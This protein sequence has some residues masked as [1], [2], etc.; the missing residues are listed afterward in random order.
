MPPPLAH[1]AFKPAEPPAPADDVISSQWD[2]ALTRS[3][4]WGRLITG[5][6]SLEAAGSQFC[7]WGGGL[8]TSSRPTWVLSHPNC[9]RGRAC[10]Q[11]PLTALGLPLMSPHTPHWRCHRLPRSLA[12]R[13]LPS[14][15]LDAPGNRDRIVHCGD[16]RRSWGATARILGHLRL[17]GGKNC[18]FS[19]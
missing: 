1:S 3:P 11:A 7:P 14:A 15:G 17:Q 8:L 13:P 12:P 4:R 18:G 6:P 5:F 9:T 19:T 16:P 10:D 2:R